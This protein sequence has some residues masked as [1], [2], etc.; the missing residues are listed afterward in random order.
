MMKITFKVDDTWM[1]AIWQSTMRRADDEDQPLG[2]EAQLGDP[3]E[4]ADQF[5]PREC[6]R[7]PG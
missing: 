2:L 1:P 5:E 4:E 7:R 3:V 6:R